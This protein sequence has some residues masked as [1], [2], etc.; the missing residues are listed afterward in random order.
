MKWVIQNGKIRNFTRDTKKK[1]S[2]FDLVL[3]IY[4]WLLEKLL[5]M[6]RYGQYL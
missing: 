2:L 4:I 5:F 3:F 1:Y 6:Y